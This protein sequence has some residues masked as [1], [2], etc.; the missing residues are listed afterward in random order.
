MKHYL[1]SLFFLW[2]CV[3]GVAQA[4]PYEARVVLRNVDVKQLISGSFDT[5]FENIPFAVYYR[6]RVVSGKLKSRARPLL[7]SAALFSSQANSEPALLL[8]GFIRKNKQSG[9]HVAASIVDSTLRIHF[10]DKRNNIYT[11]S[12]KL[13]DNT[14]VLSARLNKAPAFFHVDS[15]EI[16]RAHV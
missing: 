1:G 3:L 8:Q 9:F 2:L 5:D 10:R 12:V 4:S 7:G 16:G 6:G 14:P 15:E 13:T 11:A